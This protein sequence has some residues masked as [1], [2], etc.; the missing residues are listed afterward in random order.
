MGTLTL[1]VDGPTLYNQEGIYP[2]GGGGYNQDIFAVYR[3]ITGVWTPAGKGLISSTSNWL[4]KVYDLHAH[5]AA[6][7]TSEWP[8][9]FWR[10]IICLDELAY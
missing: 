7:L 1:Q 10:Q 6:V 2:G 9:L 3:L 5:S 8:N 4:K